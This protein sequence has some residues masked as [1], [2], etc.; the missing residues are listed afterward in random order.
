M[1][2]APSSSP[3]EHRTSTTASSRATITAPRSL[4]GS[5]AR[6]HRSLRALTA[7]VRAYANW[8]VV[9]QLARTQRVTRDPGHAEARPPG[10]GQGDQA[11][12]VAV[13]PGNSAARRHAKTSS[14]PG[15]P[16]PPITDTIS[17]LRGRAV[18]PRA[19]SGRWP[20]GP[21]HDGGSRRARFAAGCEAGAGAPS[22][23]ACRG[24]RGRVA[25]F[26]ELAADPW[27]F[28]ARTRRD[29]PLGAAS[30]R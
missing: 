21:G 25:V 20:A 27:R 2:T 5:G 4:A 11:G 13:R 30:A 24:G 1:R 12:P 15:A 8:Q 22:A 18:R 7:R 14:T 23:S 28:P 17:V 3:P 10:R 26:L 6:P 9:H 16:Q 29:A 19:D